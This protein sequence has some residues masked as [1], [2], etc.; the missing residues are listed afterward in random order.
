MVVAEVVVWAAV[1]ASGGANGWARGFGGI[2]WLGGVGWR[3]GEL[4]DIDPWL[5][6]PARGKSSPIRVYPPYRQTC[7]PG[8]SE[9]VSKPKS[10]CMEAIQ[11]PLNTSLTVRQDTC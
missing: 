4:F 2:L 5:L 8:R 9:N 3:F 7:S 10:A 11:R 1:A 6:D